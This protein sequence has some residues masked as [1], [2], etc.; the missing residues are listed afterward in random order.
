MNGEFLS[1]EQIHSQFQSYIERQ[2]NDDPFRPDSMRVLP[3]KLA[4]ITQ[5]SKPQELVGRSY[6]TFRPHGRERFMRDSSISLMRRGDET[7]FGK[8]ISVLRN[9]EYGTE[10]EILYL[11]L[12]DKI[13]DFELRSRDSTFTLAFVQGRI[14]TNNIIGEDNEEFMK[15]IL[16]PETFDLD[17]IQQTLLNN[18]LYKDPYD[19]DSSADL[20]WRTTNLARLLGV[21]R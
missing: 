18:D 8:T 11:S 10:R 2:F 13:V 20:A 5:Q 12:E 9:S 16:I 6:Y 14:S 15:S 7:G 21:R 4:C 3:D 17:K 1:P 19:A